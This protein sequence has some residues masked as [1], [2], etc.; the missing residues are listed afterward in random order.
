MIDYH[1]QWR[2]GVDNKHERTY[3]LYLGAVKIAEV[4]IGVE[5]P[6]VNAYRLWLYDRSVDWMHQDETKWMAQHH[7]SLVDIIDKVQTEIRKKFS[8]SCFVDHDDQY[9]CIF[10]Q[11]PANVLET[12]AK[13]AAKAVYATD[14]TLSSLEQKVDKLID[15]IAGFCTTFKEQFCTQT[16]DAEAAQ[17]EKPSKDYIRVG[18]YHEK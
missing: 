10:K 14:T 9:I 16:V 12:E 7:A 5:H 3:E 13:F 15:L 11:L 6:G 18:L 17:V 1:F 2:A 4:R 8:T